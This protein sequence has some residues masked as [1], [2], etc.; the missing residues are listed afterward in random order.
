MTHRDPLINTKTHKRAGAS[1]GPLDQHQRTAFAVDYGTS[2]ANV[3]LLTKGWLSY[4][5][6]R[7]AWAWNVEVR[8]HKKFDEKGLADLFN[9][10]VKY[11]NRRL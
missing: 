11:S 4:Q 9:E 2:T 3:V 1:F 5:Q 7:D 10:M 6:L 8:H